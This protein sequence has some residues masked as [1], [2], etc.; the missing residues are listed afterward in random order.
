MYLGEEVGEKEGLRKWK[1]EEVRKACVHRAS[2][3]QP[4]CK[5]DVQPLTGQTDDTENSLTK[6]YPW[7]RSHTVPLEKSPTVSVMSSR[8]LC[9]VMMRRS[10]R[11][12][13]IS[14]AMC[15]ATRSRGEHQRVPR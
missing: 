12:I 1:L 10:G 13:T 5:H 9:K 7:P 14:V 3:K 11:K 6:E 2:G 15:A 8:L 4:Y